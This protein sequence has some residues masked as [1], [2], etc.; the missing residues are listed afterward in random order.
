MKPKH[1]F[2]LLIFLLFVFLILV[3]TDYN[4]NYISNNTIGIKLHGGLG[5]QLFEIAS[6]YC[7]A[8]SQ[9]KSLIVVN[10]S[11]NHHTQSDYFQT[12]FRKVV[13][14]PSYR[15]T[16]TY[17][18]A[19]E[20]G[21]RYVE[22]PLYKENAL[23]E[24]YFQSEKYFHLCRDDILKLFEIEPE[25]KK[26]LIEKVPDL[27][28]YFIH[29]RRGDYLKSDIHNVD[30]SNY[31]KKALNYV[32][33]LD[34]NAKFMVFSDDIQYCMGLDL[35]KNKDNIKY[36]NNKDF[37]ELDS[38]YLMS[39]C[40]RG[41]I[42]ANSSFSWWAGYLNTNPKKIVTYPGKWLNNDW[43]KEIGW[44]GCVVIDV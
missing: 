22:L 1:K 13:Y 34:A 40:K 24:G 23:Y 9:N 17:T 27:D 43:I 35:F 29:I 33:N 21:L 18:E 32:S 16:K 31:Y 7:F 12:I 11:K 25:R 28:Y 3:Y 30:L 36:T 39:M 15:Y 26:R 14:D 4:E 41:G 38:L 8:K 19:L 6:I 42:G 20:D 10:K 2:I 5:N 44:K 37:D